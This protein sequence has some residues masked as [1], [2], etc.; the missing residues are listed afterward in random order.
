MPNLS[1]A[2]LAKAYP[3]SGNELIPLSQPDPKQNYALTTF[4]TTISSLANYV[5]DAA[6]P[7]GVIWSHG[8]SFDP[9]KN[10]VPKGWLLCDGTAVQIK[11]YRRLYEAIGD[12]YG[13]SVLPGILFKLPNLKGRFIIGYNSLQPT[14]TPTF[15][16]FQGDPFAFGQYGGEF[17]HTLSE[18]E[19]PNHTHEVEVIPAE[20]YFLAA[21]PPR[22][23]EW[24]IEQDQAVPPNGPGSALVQVN[25]NPTMLNYGGSRPHNTTPP[26]MALNYIIKY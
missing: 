20:K 22:S 19:M 7:A 3:L 24:A 12:S 4:T 5:R 14:Q 26:Y 15:G 6:I 16:Q 21:P 1:I 11:S 10:S 17:N 18:S 8:G 23:G 25:Y 2:Q 13:V 9:I